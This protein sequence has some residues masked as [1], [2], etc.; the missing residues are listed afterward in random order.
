MLHDLPQITQPV[1]A[2]I[3]TLLLTTMLLNSMLR[4]DPHPLGIYHGPSLAKCRT[5]ISSLNPGGSP[6][7]EPILL[8]TPLYGWRNQGSGI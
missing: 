2:G 6:K 8:F 3:G 7:K 4:D 5:C 1:G